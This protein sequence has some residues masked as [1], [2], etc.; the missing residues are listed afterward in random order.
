M[1]RQLTLIIRSSA[2]LIGAY[3]NLEKAARMKRSQI[4]FNQR[5][6]IVSKQKS[7]SYFSI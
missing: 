4:A 6:T 7:Y 3:V 1:S 2:S 5:L